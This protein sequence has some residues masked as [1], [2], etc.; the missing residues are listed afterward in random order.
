M[1]R[2]VNRVLLGLAGLV[3]LCA[4]GAVLAAGT[5]LSVPSWW[6]YDGRDDVLL[7]RADRYRWRDEGWWWPVVI[8][9]LAVLVLLAVWWLLAQLRRARLAEILVDSG[10]G[11]GALLRGRALEGVLEGEVESLEGVARARVSLTGRRSTPEARVGLLLE[12]FAAPGEALTRL[13]DEALAHARDSAGLAS[14]PAEVR[15]RAAKHGARRVS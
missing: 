12:P 8:A 4:G 9:V 15:L 2:V 6:P 7:S 11:E 13:T 1:L 14:L 10:D 3:L 5:G